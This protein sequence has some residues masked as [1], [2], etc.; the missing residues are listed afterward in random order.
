MILDKMESNSQGAGVAEHRES[1]RRQPTIRNVAERAGVSKS[2]VS[3]VMRGEPMV[4][5]DKRRR[6]LQAAEELGYTVPAT[7]RSHAVAQAGT[8]AVL[9]SDLRNPLLIDVV[10]KAA[11]VL[12]AAGLS[13]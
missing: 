2:L 4:S 12:E 10:E 6:V 8:V 5:E 7:A 11:P 3:L 1:S 13:M 9:V